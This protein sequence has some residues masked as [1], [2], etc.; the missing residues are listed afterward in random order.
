MAP[1]RADGALDRH[2]PGRASRAPL[3][4]DQLAEQL[5]HRRPGLRAG[6]DDFAEERQDPDGVDVA[7][8]ARG[9]LPAVAPEPDVGIR[10]SLT[11][12]DAAGD[13]PDRPLLDQAPRRGRVGLPRAARD[14]PYAYIA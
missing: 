4:P 8:P 3:R 5:H 2:A 1:V 9:A 6:P 7:G 12:R 13:Q 10:V 11:R 14:A